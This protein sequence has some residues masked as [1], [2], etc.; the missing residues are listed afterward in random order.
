MPQGEALA[1]MSQFASGGA[2]ILTVRIENVKLPDATLLQVT[3]DFTPVGTI[4]LSPGEGT[5][6]TSL[7]HFGVSRDQVRVNNAGATILAGGL[8]R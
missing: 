1:D 4:S 2:T 5:L 3:L 7:G 8:F 6:T